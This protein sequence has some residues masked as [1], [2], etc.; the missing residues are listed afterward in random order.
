MDE[1]AEPSTAE[2]GGAQSTNTG[3]CT[4]KEL[5]SRGLDF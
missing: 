2:R 3:M 1:E 4:W 5:K